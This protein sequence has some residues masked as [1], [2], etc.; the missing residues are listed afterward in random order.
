MGVATA[1]RLKDRTPA[2]LMAS[3][4]TAIRAIIDLAGDDEDRD[5]ATDELLVLGVSRQELTVAL[6]DD[7]C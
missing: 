3:R 1:L 7:P 2:D 4:L 5:V 6:F